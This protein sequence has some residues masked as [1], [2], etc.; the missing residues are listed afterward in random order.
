[1]VRGKRPSLR[2]RPGTGRAANNCLSAETGLGVDGADGDCEDD[3]G[4]VD[5]TYV[6][7]EGRGERGKTMLKCPQCRA[8]L[9]PV[10]EHILNV[11]ACPHCQGE[12]VPQDSFNAVRRH[13]DPNWTDEQKKTFCKLSESS[14]AEGRIRCPQCNTR[15]EKQSA[16]HK[17]GITVDYCH[18]CR[19]YWFAAG[20]VEKLQIAYEEEAK[21][22]TPEDWAKIEQLGRAALAL[23]VRKERLAG[24]G[25]EMARLGSAPRP[26][27]EVR[28]RIA[29]AAGVVGLV[30]V[31]LSVFHS[32]W[33]MDRQAKEAE[34]AGERVMAGLP[35]DPPDEAWSLL[36][37]MTGS[38]AGRLA[39]A[40]IIVV[41]VVGAWLLL[42]R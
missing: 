10:G 14:Q 9:K 8:V 1:L 20:E 12:L 41:T 29:G 24:Y 36:E 34:E 31:V 3:V 42:R 16:D 18:E 32:V 37:A 13:A 30:S 27:D 35:A 2:G 11:L 22:R 19:M 6:L 7:A 26:G 38:W 25:D 21:N 17:A 4:S 15:M 5:P 28:A 39:L 33:A 23:E 40:A